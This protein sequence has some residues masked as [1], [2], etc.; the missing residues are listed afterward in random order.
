MLVFLAFAAAITAERTQPPP[1]HSKTTI[2]TFCT[3][4][5]TAKVYLHT[6]LS[7]RRR[8]QPLKSKKRK[9]LNIVKTRRVPEPQP[10][11]ELSQSQSRERSRAK[12][13]AERK[14]LKSDAS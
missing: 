9:G 13:T 10:G 5:A 7:G 12:A 3:L 8:S 14:P 6:H 2:L 4:A 11:P 1:L